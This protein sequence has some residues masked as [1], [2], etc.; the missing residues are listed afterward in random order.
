M[1]GGHFD[2]KQV[3]LGYIADQLDEDI[4]YND[5]SWEEPVK[6]DDEEYSGYQFSPE[7]IAFMKDTVQQLRDLECTLR[8]LD[9]AMSG[10]TGEETLKSNLNIQSSD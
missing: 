10:D 9:L 4:Q 1:S 2:Y 7:T 8:E 3:Y 6:V 5:V